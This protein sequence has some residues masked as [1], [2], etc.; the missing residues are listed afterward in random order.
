MTIS[1]NKYQFNLKYVAIALVAVFLTFFFHEGAHYVTGKLLGY[2]MWMNLNAAGLVEGKTY[3]KEW[4][5]QLVSISG[6]IFT[7]IQAI[8]FFYVIKKTKSI[9]WYPFLFI[10][11]MMRIFASV[12]SATVNANDEARVSEWLGIGKMTLPIIISLFL[13]YLVIKTAIAQKIK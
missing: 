6:P 3:D 11:A 7:V 13:V 9:S 12:I 2:D 10:A 4:H 8:A 5:Y 1:D